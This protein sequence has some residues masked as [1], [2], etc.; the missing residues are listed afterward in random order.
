ME[1]AI[2]TLEIELSK[3]EDA[4]R[5]EEKYS[6]YPQYVPPQPPIDWKSR[7]SELHKAIEVLR[8]YPI[9]TST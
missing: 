5:T 2:R 9:T 8:Q 6:V 1:Y 7:I 4:Q 3:V